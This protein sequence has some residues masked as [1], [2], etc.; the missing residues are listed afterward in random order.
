MG[1]GCETA[2]VFTAS[3]RKPRPRPRAQ[4][5]RRPSCRWAGTV[6]RPCEH[7]LQGLPVPRGM[8]YQEAACFTITLRSQFFQAPR[9]IFIHRCRRTLL[10]LIYFLIVL[11]GWT[12]S[13]S[14]ILELRASRLRPAESPVEPELK[15]LF[16]ADYFLLPPP[17]SSLLLLLL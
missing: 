16:N 3:S 8:G 17:P 7:L 15:L 10:K 9:S 12:S 5:R 4:K 11:S 1:I 6:S 14:I 13:S 2:V